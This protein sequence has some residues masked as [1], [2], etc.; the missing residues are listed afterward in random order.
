MPQVN[1]ILV[2]DD[3]PLYLLLVKKTIIKYEFA[4]TISAFS[5]GLEAFDS[6]KN[7]INVPASLPDIILLDINMPIMDGWDFL[8]QF[9]PFLQ[10]TQKKISI[11]IVTSSIAEND[12][13][14]AKTYP[15]IKDYLLKPIDQPILIRVIEEHNQQKN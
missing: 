2:I 10:K 1:N 11:Y 13:I 15:T 6:L 9:L 14:K 3:D 4:K 5:N 7:L 12:K 8:D